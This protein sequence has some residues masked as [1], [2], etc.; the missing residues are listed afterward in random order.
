MSHLRA[1]Y[2]F[3]VIVVGT[4]PDIVTHIS[5]STFLHIFAACRQA[6]T[7]FWLVSLIKSCTMKATTIQ[8]VSVSKNP[9]PWKGVD[10]VCAH[11][12][13]KRGKGCTTFDS[14]SVAPND[15]KTR[16]QHENRLQLFCRKLKICDQNEEN[17][18]KPNSYRKIRLFHST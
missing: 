4:L 11:K 10:V 5:D 1:Y 12:I 17:T 7:I 16:Y 6:V 14:V 2:F 15:L 3:I 13:A 18:V 8:V 9:R